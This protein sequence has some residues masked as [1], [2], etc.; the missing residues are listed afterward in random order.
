VVRRDFSTRTQRRLPVRLFSPAIRGF[1]PT[2]VKGFVYHFAASHPLVG[3]VY[4]SLTSLQEL[5]KDSQRLSDLKRD[6]ERFA[7]EFDWMTA[8]TTDLLYASTDIRRFARLASIRI[9]RNPFADRAT[10]QRSSL[11]PKPHGSSQ[12]IELRGT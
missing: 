3:A 7:D 6:T 12:Y 8:L 10:T 4:E 5:K 9:R 2:G 11:E 1:Q